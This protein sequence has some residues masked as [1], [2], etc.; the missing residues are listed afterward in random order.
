MQDNSLTTVSK[1]T[2]PAR[3]QPL[4][5]PVRP[6]VSL[7]E[8]E[9]ISAVSE[10]IERDFFPSLK[11]MRMQNALL[12]AVERG[13]MHAAKR[14]GSDIVCDDAGRDSS[15]MSHNEPQQSL[16]AFQTTHTSEDNL[17]FAKLIDAENK[18]RREKL[19]WAFGNDS[20]GKLVIEPPSSRLQIEP[21]PTSSDAAANSKHEDILPVTSSTAA[22]T[23]SPNSSALIPTQTDSDE[24]PPHPSALSAPIPHHSKPI[25]TWSYTPKNTLMYPPDGAP[26]TL[27]D[28]V[29]PRTAKLAPKS[30][31]HA[32]TRLPTDTPS[33]SNQLLRAASKLAADRLATQEVWRSMAAATPALFQNSN[34]SSD[35]TTAAPGFNLVPSTPSFEPHADIDPED[36]FTWG[37]IDGTPLLIDQPS[38]NG[39]AKGFRIP[40]TPRREVVADRLAEKAK[41]DMKLRAKGS[42]SATTPS[43]MDRCIA[44]ASPYALKSPNVSNARMLSPAAQKLF[45]KTRAASSGGLFGAKG[46]LGK[47]LF[48]GSVDDQLRASYSP[49]ASGTPGGTPKS[50]LS[51][52]TPRLAGVVA[53]SPMV[54]VRASASTPVVVGNLKISSVTAAAKATAKTQ[55]TDNLLDF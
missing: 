50:S 20:K 25:H 11:R 46:G 3:L 43:N 36:L 19:T 37:M 6:H 27:T 2:L 5:P 1:Q 28:I 51:K 17:S 30:I 10:I 53:A 44:S 24:Q 9:Y 35:P 15:T 40:D 16:D 8:D 18:A 39:N 22:A 31:N 38:G 55:L 54:A 26:L 13:D 52:A 4:P 32:G 49:R 48:T 45:G 34:S 7:E 47:R 29:N 41:R 33:A 14:I 12:D 42:S 23:T 21:A